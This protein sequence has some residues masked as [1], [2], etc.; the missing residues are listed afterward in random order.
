M[1]VG[2]ALTY[3]ELRD[4]ETR[5][6]DQV[7]AELAGLRHVDH[8]TGKEMIGGRT[9]D[10]EGMLIPYN[11]PGTSNTV[12]YRL[13]RRNPD[14]DP[15]GKPK[16]KYV[17]A[18]GDRNRLYVPPLITVEHLLDTSI[19]IIWVEGELKALALRRLASWGGVD[20]PRFIPIALS[21]V[22]NFIGT[23]GATN[24][25]HGTR[26]PV[27]GPIPDLDL[28]AYANRNMLI[29]FDSDAVSKS[30]VRAARHSFSVEL[31]N[32]G[33]NVGYLEWDGAKGKGPDDWIANVGPDIVLAA[34]ANVEFN[35][36][37]GWEAKLLC[38]DTGKPKG[39]VENARLALEMVP[40][41]AGLA[42]D[43]FSGRI[44]RPASCPWPASTGKEWGDLDSIEFTAWLQRHK[45]DI[46]KEVAHDAVQIVAARNKFHPVRDYFESL[47]WDGVPRV[48]AWLTRY[49]GVEFTNYSSAAGRCWLISAVARIM[50]PGCKADVALLLIGP[51]GKRKSTVCRIL[52][53]P[54]FSDN[55]PDLGDKDAQM[56]VQ[57]H[58]ILEM[59][60]LAALNKT[61][62]TQVKAYMSRSEDVYRPPYGRSVV[63][64]KRQCVFIA[65]T[66]EGEPLKDT[67]G[68]RRFWPVDV[69]DID[70]DAL[71][72]DKDQLWAEAV[73]LYKSGATWWFTSETLNESARAEQAN[74]VEMHV[75]HDAIAYWLR[76][77]EMVTVSE[78]LEGAIKKDLHSRTQADKVGVVKVL[79]TLGWKQTMRRI[80]GK[81]TKVYLNPE[82]LHIP[83]KDEEE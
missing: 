8:F 29:A 3:A 16:Q 41:F 33:A 69:G 52:G 53:E 5:W 35:T 27:K 39:L 68:N 40:E 83:P 19:P 1:L 75:W 62:L 12:T 10:Y 47:E 15:S 65:T 60:E 77:R 6:I 32:R 36:A 78:I 54:Y 26:V 70:T 44:M 20:K 46:R 23:I 31:R 73:E 13:R 37:T 11:M 14:V 66:N 80:N 51:E 57:G 34:I 42:L 81:R 72:I 9:G 56:H 63:H 30:S 18:A 49:V 76:D 43:E 45:I 17:A 22:W 7:W 71:A 74:R 21:G 61:A 64:Q 67:T 38:T 2:D 50:Q 4:L 58:F 55:I 59:Q 24:N 82:M 48:D 79:Q 25:E 28:M